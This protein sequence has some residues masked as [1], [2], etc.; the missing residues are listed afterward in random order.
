MRIE[1]LLSAGLHP[2]EPV[3]ITQDAHE[4]SSVGTECSDDRREDLANFEDLLELAGHG[5]SSEHRR[6]ELVELGV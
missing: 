2:R 3:D 4:I 6:L 5:W 1:V